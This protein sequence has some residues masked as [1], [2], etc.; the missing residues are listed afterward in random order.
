MLGF[1]RRVLT[2]NCPKRLGD[3]LQRGWTIGERPEH[4]NHPSARCA[5]FAKC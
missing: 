4:V 5:R 3:G 1:Q 2:V